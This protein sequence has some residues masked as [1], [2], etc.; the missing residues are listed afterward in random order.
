MPRKPVKTAAKSSAKSAT[1]PA[2]TKAGARAAQAAPPRVP[3]EHDRFDYSA[4]GSVVNLAARLCGEAKDGQILVESKVHAA[5]EANADLEPIGE[6]TLKGFHRPIR[7]FNVRA[8][9]D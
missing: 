9:R 7:A 5:I 6:L 8:L 1:K 3:T 2:A 4:I